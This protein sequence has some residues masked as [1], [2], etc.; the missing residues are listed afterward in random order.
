M[1]LLWLI[2]TVLR[3]HREEGA[4]EREKFWSWTFLALNALLLLLGWALAWNAQA[5]YDYDYGVFM[6]LFAPRPLV[7]RSVDYALSVASMWRVA[8]L[9]GCVWVVADLTQD[10]LGRV[11]EVEKVA[12]RQAEPASQRWPPTRELSPGR[13]VWGDQQI[14]RISMAKTSDSLARRRGCRSAA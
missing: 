1:A 13:A 8:A 11:I 9:L 3:P 5:L 4:G 14:C 10:A 6:P 2:G 12:R 7:C